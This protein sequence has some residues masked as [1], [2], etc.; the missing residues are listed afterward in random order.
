VKPEFSITN[1]RAAPARIAEQPAQQPHFP[2]PR[3]SLLRNRRAN[4][5]RVLHG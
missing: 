2:S 1:E 5:R 3:T 4:N